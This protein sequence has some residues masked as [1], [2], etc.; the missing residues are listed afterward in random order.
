MGSSNDVLALIADLLLFLAALRLFG[1]VFLSQ[2]PVPASF[3]GRVALAGGA[4]ALGLAALL[5]GAGIEDDLSS[6]LLVGM[7]SVAVVL[8]ILGGLFAG[9][10]LAKGTVVAAGVV[11]LAAELLFVGELVNLGLLVWLSAAVLLGVAVMAVLRDS[12]A[13]RSAALGSALIT[14]MVAALAGLLPN[15]L[16]GNLNDEELRRVKERAHT[17]QEAIEEL[18]DRAIAQAQLAASALEASA[19]FVAAAQQGDGAGMQAVLAV[20][21]SQHFGIDVL[22]YFTPS[23]QVLGADGAPIADL[24]TW[25]ESTTVGATL[26]GDPSGG[27]EDLGDSALVAIGGSMAKVSVLPQPPG[28]AAEPYPAGAPYTGVAY[29]SAL[30]VSFS[31]TAGL[32]GAPA[33]VVVAGIRL[34]ADSLGRNLHDDEGVDLTLVSG[35]SI[36]ST[37]DGPR[38]DGALDERPGGELARRAIETGQP[39]N[40]QAS[41]RGTTVFSAARPIRAA[42]GRVV[43]ALLVTT[44][45]RIEDSFRNALMPTLFLVLAIPATLLL[46]AG[47]IAGIRVEAPVRRLTRAA[48]RMGEGD[49]SM[50]TS[51]ATEARGDVGMLGA[52]L[53]SMAGSID[54]LTSDL[55]ETAAKLNAV[56]GGMTEAVVA[57]DLDGV[58]VLVN[59]AAQTLLGDEDGVVGQ[60]FTSVVRGHDHS[61]APFSEVFER[62][63]HES[64]CFATGFLH[65]GDE[66]LPVTMSCAPIHTH[67]SGVVGG[68]IAR[69]ATGTVCVLRDTRREFEVEQMK[70]EFLAGVSHELRTPLAPIKGYAEMLL[71][72]ELSHKQTREFVESIIESSDELE[73]VVDILVDFSAIEANNFV[74]QMGKIDVREPVRDAVVE[75]SQRDPA[76][77]WKVDVAASAVYLEA[78]RRLLQRSVEELADNAASYSPDGSMITVRVREGEDVAGSSGIS[79]RFVDITV[80]D[81]GHGLTPQ[82]FAVLDSDDPLGTPSRSRTGGFGLGLPFVARVARAHGGRVIATTRDEGGS[83][84]TIRL[85][86]GE[87]F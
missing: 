83:S 56:L 67:I 39:S 68:P 40:G 51:I 32:P 65:R 30:R 50:Q 7:R 20:T 36:V 25:Q 69:V 49:L 52:S 13:L 86:A 85:P 11:L 63:L 24:S 43:A 41:F 26:E 4:L 74:L 1:T 48:Q 81:Q 75:C 35:S 27:I 61:G 54:T 44:E 29:P 33:G 14:V 70:T 87:N 34:D 17:E 15:V 46:A 2:A 16:L 80:E 73:R 18:I 79:T 77:E 23:G 42:D 12:L 8:L 28:P 6:G 38:S 59:A 72:K 21:R 84:F 9:V 19:A 82:M 37:F 5:H 58:V 62:V 60:H 55:Q 10:P 22:A 64:R 57:T 31:Q 3:V 53:A 71:R 76:H 66:L 45:G 47:L 78:D